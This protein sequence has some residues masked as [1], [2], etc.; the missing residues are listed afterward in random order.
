MKKGL[1]II[2]SMLFASMMACD[3]SASTRSNE[4]ESTTTHLEPQK[5]DLSSD[6][7]NYYLKIT[8]YTVPTND[9]QHPNNYFYTIQ[10]SLAGFSFFNAIIG[11]VQYDYYKTKQ[12]ENFINLDS[13]GFAEFQT[14]QAV[15][16]N[17]ASGIVQF[18][19]YID[20]SDLSKAIKLDSN[21]FLE[22]LSVDETIESFGIQKI[23]IYTFDSLFYDM[24]FMDVI[25]TYYNKSNEIETLSLNAGGYGTF[26][27]F[28]HKFNK[29][30]DII[31][32]TGYIFSF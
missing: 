14:N 29:D 12:E 15:E 2:I 16:F 30:V 3:F 32:L 8:Y 7:Y 5:F 26:G 10:S 21:N 31:S 4:N 19:E 23:Y 17:S 13:S 22:Y 25:I 27:F 1:L 9:F 11:Y 28:E 6:N 20:I 24:L 18:S